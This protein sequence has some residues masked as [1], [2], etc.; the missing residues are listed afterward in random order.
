[1]NIC[2]RL[3]LLSLVV[4]GIAGEDVAVPK[5]A[6]K[7]GLAGRVTP[8]KLKELKVGWYYFWA[9]RVPDD[10]PQGIEKEVAAAL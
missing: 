9:P 1:M 2:L 6:S 8:D 7:K 4:N 10:T 5:P 3:I